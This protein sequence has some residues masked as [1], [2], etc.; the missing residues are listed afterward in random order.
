[1]NRELKFYT[2]KKFLDLPKSITLKYKSL[3]ILV[4]WT[5]K[6]NILN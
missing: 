2:I 4:I 5:H 1:M 6:Y 3:E